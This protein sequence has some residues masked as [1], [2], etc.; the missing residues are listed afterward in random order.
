MDDVSRSVGEIGVVFEAGRIV[1]VVRYGSGFAPFAA[2]M[3][4]R[5]EPFQPRRE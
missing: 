2:F 1:S 4:G 5:H 3:E